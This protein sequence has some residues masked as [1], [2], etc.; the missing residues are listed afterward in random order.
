MEMCDWQI[1]KMCEQDIDEVEQIEKEIFSVPWS[2]KSFLDAC[3]NENN[4]YLTCII[5]GEVAG[6]CGLW[7]VLGEGNITNMAVSHKHRRKGIGMALMQEM[8]KRGHEKEV[9]VFFL[10]VRESNAAARA[11][12]EELGYEQIGVRKRFYEKPVENA[13]IM[14]KGWRI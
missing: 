14:S 5:D 13:V 6:Y 1:R 12:Y 4:I 2:A 10:E 3:K 11:L 8:E 9:S 7:T